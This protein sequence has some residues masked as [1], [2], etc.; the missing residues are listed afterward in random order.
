[1]ADRKPLDWRQTVLA[2]L[3]AAGI[4][5]G[6]MSLGVLG[7]AR[8]EAQKVAVLEQQMQQ[9]RKTSVRQHE[10]ALIEIRRLQ[11]RI[12]ELETRER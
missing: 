5:T 8:L 12:G 3:A 10:F 7:T 4:S 11:D 2:A 6:G 9:I 1:V